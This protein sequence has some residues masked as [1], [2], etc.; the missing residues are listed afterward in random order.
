MSS[1]IHLGIIKKWF[2]SIDSHSKLLFERENGI[3]ELVLLQ[4]NNQINN[5]IG[6]RAPSV[7]STVLSF[8]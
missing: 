5:H 7:N 6:L 4:D 1:N 8:K 3:S 2:D